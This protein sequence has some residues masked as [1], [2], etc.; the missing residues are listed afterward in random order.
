MLRQLESKTKLSKYRSAFYLKGNKKDGYFYI[1]KDNIKTIQ[2]GFKIEN[3][4]KALKLLDDY[5]YRNS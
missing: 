3:K 2:I 5:L 4:K 1:K